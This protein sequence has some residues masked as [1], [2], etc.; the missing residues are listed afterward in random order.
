MIN[1][2]IKSGSLIVSHI[3]FHGDCMI[4]CLLLNM[5]LRQHMFTL[6]NWITVVFGAV[7]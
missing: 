1:I 4:G 7:S 2:L 6:R 5:N 3:K